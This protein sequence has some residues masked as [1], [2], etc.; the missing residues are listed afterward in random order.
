MYP[1]R[2]QVEKIEKKKEKAETARKK[3]VEKV[4]GGEADE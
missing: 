2:Y 1:S 3:A 4:F